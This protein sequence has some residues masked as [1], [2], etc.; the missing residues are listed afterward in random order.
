MIK[1]IR[2]R[3][4][5]SECDNP[6]IGANDILGTSDRSFQ[7]LPIYRKFDYTPNGTSHLQ[8][9]GRFIYYDYPDSHDDMYKF[10]FTFKI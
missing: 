4:Y 2:R 10:L 7:G 3:K 6:N 5:T 9:E 8:Q 1:R